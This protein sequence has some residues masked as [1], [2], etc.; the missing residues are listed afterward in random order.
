MG[1]TWPA[2]VTLLCLL[3]SGT[4]LAQAVSIGGRLGLSNSA[5]L[6]ADEHSGDRIDDRRGLQV[7]GIVA[8]ELNSILSLQLELSYV[9]KG[10]A[11]FETGGDR[12]LTY[13]E[14]PLLLSISAPWTTSPHL[15]VGPSVSHEL[16][17]SV[18]G[19]PQVGSVSCSDPQLGWDREK[20][21]LGLWF[22]LGL[23]RRFGTSTLDIQFIGNVSLTD[24]NREALPPGY[25]R[26]VAVTASA[27]YK[28][29]L[30]GL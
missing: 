18:T 19:V 21:L 30:G 29:S 26:L 24:M 12:K 5:A 4:A 17:C 16:S 13:L 11:E 27:V 14:L 22:G 10:W 7:G 20:L 8:H 2:T 15:L 9:Q 23:G 28:I 6:F 25:I 3:G 1:R